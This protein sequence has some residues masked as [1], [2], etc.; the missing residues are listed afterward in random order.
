MLKKIADLG[1]SL[2]KIEQQKVLGGFS[3]SEIASSGFKCTCPDGRSK[4]VSNG[5]ECRIFCC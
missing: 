2:S 3:S 4:T 5:G 1:S